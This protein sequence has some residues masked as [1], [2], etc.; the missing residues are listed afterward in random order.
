M[1][2]SPFARI[3]LFL[4]VA[5]F[6]ARADIRLDYVGRYVH[7]SGGPDHL[8]GVEQVGDHHALVCSNL[9]LTL[10]D[11]NALP[12]QG[13]Q[14][15]VARLPGLDTFTSYTRPDG[16]CYVN[17]RQG[18]FA[19]VRVDIPGQSLT[20]L[21]EIAEPGVFYEKMSVVGDRLYVAAHAYGIRIF[22]LTNPA[23]PVLIGELTAGFDD[24]W[25]IAVDGTTAYV[26]DG[27]GGLKIVDITN[28]MQPVIVVG[29]DTDSAAAT[30]EDVMVIGDHVYVASGGAGIAV[31]PRGSLTP[32]RLF[33][34]PIAAKHLARAG[35]YLAVV[36]MGGLHVFE[37]LPDGGLSP[38]VRELAMRRYIQGEG[39]QLRLWHG[40]SSW[41]SDRFLAAN[42]D[43]MDIYRLVDPAAS[44]QPDVTA[45]AQRLRFPPTGGIEKI[46]VTND[47]SGPLTITNV[48]SNSGRFNAFPKQALLQPGDQF[49]LTVEYLGGQPGSGM[50][51][52]RSDDPDEDPLPIQVFGETQYL[53]PTEPA[54]PFTLEAWTYDHQAQQFNKQP[55]TL[56]AQTGKV[57][58]FHVFGS[59]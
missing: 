20:K 21:R 25:A 56:A 16:Y 52:I 22:D 42:W 57:V 46:T 27:A 41:G 48:A 36:D 7:Q 1:R 55:F 13:T 30:A 47:G 50:L 40:L 2:N 26:A 33:D 24:A 14:A 32:R 54:T 51:A 34:T 44:S 10:I 5:A 53:D 17:L 43:T 18:G 31:Y 58:Y 45:S 11:L 3:V 4:F 38:A 8:M 12:M 23:N 28:E 49:E 35:N 59:W 39:L 15:Y 29:E 37:I 6:V 19:V 9:A